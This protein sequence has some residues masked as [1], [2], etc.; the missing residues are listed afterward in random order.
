MRMGKQRKKIVSMILLVTFLFMMLPVTGLAATASFKDVSDSDW[1]ASAVDYVTAHNL[2]VGVSDNQFDPQGNVTRAMVVTVLWR[3]AGTPASSSKAGFSDVKAGDWYAQAINWGVEHKLAAGYSANQFGPNDPVTREQLMVFLHRFAQFNGENVPKADQT[4]LQQKFADWNQVSDWAKEAMAWAYQKGYISGITAATLGAAQSASRA[5]FAVIL[6]RIG[7]S[8]DSSGNPPKQQT[9]TVPSGSSSSSGGSSGSSSKATIDLS[10]YAETTYYYNGNIIT[11]DAE[12][13][14][15]KYGNP[16]YAKAVITG[17]G[18]IVAVAYSNSDADKLERSAKKYDSKTVDLAGKTMIPAFQDP[19]SHIDMVDQYYDASPSSGVTSLEKLVEQ[20]KKDFEKW[21]NDDTYTEEYGD[22]TTTPSNYWFVTNGF[23]NTAFVVDDYVMPT[24]KTLDQISDEYPICYIHASNHLGVVN[25]V[26]M[27]IIKTVTQRSD[28]YWDKDE[29]GELTGILREGDFYLLYFMPNVLMNS[30]TTRTASPAGVLANAMQVYASYGLTTGVS[31]GGGSMAGTMANVPEEDRIIDVQDMAAEKFSVS[32]AEAEYQDG[33]KHCGVKIFLDGS[34]QGKTAWFKE[35]PADPSGGGYYKDA[36]ENILDGENLAWWWGEAEGKKTTDGALT[37]RFV[38]CIEK[39]LQFTC[40][41]NGTGAIQQFID[42]YKAALT[43]CGYNVNDSKAVA[44]VRDRIRPVIIHSQTITLNQ[45]KE[46]SE[47][48]I[49]ISFFADHVYYYG[50]YHLGSTLG[51]I[52]GQIISPLASAL[53]DDITVTMHQDSP[54]APPNM[55]FSVYNAA[56]RITRDGQAIGRG[57]ADGSSDK[58]SRI[59][60]RQNQ[61]DDTLDERISAYDALKC[62]T[63]NSAWQNFDENSKGSITV[64]KQ[65]D[66]AILN[67][68][69]LSTEYLSLTPEEAREPKFVVQTINDG[70]V[71]YEK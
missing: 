51:P 36:D 37:I 43:E 3:Q 71:I 12:N 41:A 28:A 18:K 25:S 59:K 45:L 39:E 27:D 5:Q 21:F 44:A 11:V 46:C 47:L 54:V 7:S 29:D 52:R 50:D 69:P 55:L 23:D 30:S 32:S 6:M 1:F 14:E 24:S 70:K 58:D 31:G 53:A 13:G 22:I 9:P 49:S 8:A 63:I 16:V 34:P 17:D 38:D 15:D 20:G 19:H 62:V 26:G 67:V 40:H 57:S 4:A 42:C 56:N 68:D 65:A 48:G 66:F 33:V 2:M 61:K 35:D 60:N 64:G 10:K